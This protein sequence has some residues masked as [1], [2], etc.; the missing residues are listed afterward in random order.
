MYESHDVLLGVFLPNGQHLTI[1]V[2][3]KATL[4]KPGMYFSGFGPV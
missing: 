1:N 3:H 4:S 2:A